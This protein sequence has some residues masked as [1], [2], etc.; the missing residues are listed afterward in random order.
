MTPTGT[1]P[2]RRRVRA[3]LAA[4]VLAVVISAATT[5]GA[6]AP[7]VA[8]DTLVSS[9]PADGETLTASP[10][11]IRLTF[12]DDALPIAPQVIVF[13][14]GTPPGEAQEATVDGRDVHLALP[15]PLAEGTYRVSWSVVSSDGH[16]IEG[17][18]LF[19]LDADGD[20]VVTASATPPTTGA[21][22]DA[23]VDAT[24]SA[25]DPATGTAGTT[26]RG[27]PVLGWIGA[28]AAAAAIGAAVVLALRRRT[29]R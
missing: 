3:A 21:A 12:S 16:R 17:T 25:S 14:E 15:D 26:G 4:L 11:E 5:L 1:P 8:H 20:G 2:L 7:A 6:F 18:Y 27:I 24:A 29:T 9:S 22:T 28:I 23:P 10:A 19:H 13:P